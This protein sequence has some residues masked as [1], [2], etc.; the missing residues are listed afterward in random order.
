[1]VSFAGSAS[2][3]TP[4][5]YMWDFGDGTGAAGTLTPAHA[6]P[7]NGTYRVTL[8]VKDGNKHIAV[9]TAVVTVG[10]P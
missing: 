10:E 6:F 7:D 4:L 9:D 1:M 5:S 3:A 8:K 2:G